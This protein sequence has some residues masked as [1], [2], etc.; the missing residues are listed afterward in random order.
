M[1]AADLRNFKRRMM[2]CILATDMAKHNEDLAA[3]K[4]TLQYN[5]I[6]EDQN[7]CNLFLDKTDG[8][9]LFKSKQ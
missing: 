1:T 3:F 6:L 4:R 9:K 5:R 7:N 2:G 8:D